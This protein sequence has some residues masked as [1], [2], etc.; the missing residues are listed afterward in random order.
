MANPWEAEI[1]FTH[2]RARAL[3][4]SQFNELAP[5][6]LESFGQGWD[7][8]AL[9][10][11][12]EWVFRF[13]QRDVARDLMGY[14]IANLRRI[15]GSLPLAVPDPVFVG[16]PEGDYPYPFSGYRILKGATACS[17]ELDD[18]SRAASAAALGA[19]LRELHGQDLTG[20]AEAELPGDLIRRA[21]LEFRLSRMR[22]EFGKYEATHGQ[23]PTSILR[24]AAEEL[25][26]TAAWPG[27][28]VMS[29]GDL[30]ARH[31]MIDEAGRVGGVIDWGD[32]HR[33]DP[34]VDLSIEFSFL[35][36]AAR[37]SFE[38]AYGG[39]DEAT[40]RRARFRAIN[41][42]LLLTNYGLS[43]GDEAIAD[44]GRWAAEHVLAD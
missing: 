37:R 5:I 6:E 4:E 13:P 12:G 2:D 40:R 42:T 33:G 27:E 14:E 3:L 9:L 23:G 36:P 18:E 21:D 25:S 28:A 29:H 38:E 20:V 35:P 32:V 7:N 10:V 34:A 19:F 17:R 8:V 31:L 11:N 1:E 22:A 43:V 41:Y 15:A 16:V 39:V 30:Y 44:I 26:R 24:E